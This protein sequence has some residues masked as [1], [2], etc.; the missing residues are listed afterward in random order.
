MR[1]LKK[2]CRIV[3]AGCLWMSPS[4]NTSL[5]NGVFRGFIETISAF[6]IIILSS[7][8]RI[9]A[10]SRSVDRYVTVVR[11]HAVLRNDNRE[12]AESSSA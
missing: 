11:Q 4:F 8:Q 10:I 5:K 12:S 9:E 3:P 6:E 7:L 2:R 1:L